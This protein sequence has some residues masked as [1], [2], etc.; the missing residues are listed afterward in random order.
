MTNS[1][2]SGFETCIQ[3]QS[4][5]VQ[6]TELA[7]QIWQVAQQSLSDEERGLVGGEIDEILNSKRAGAEE[8]L[9]RMSNLSDRASDTL[10]D[11]A[12]AHLIEDFTATCTVPVPVS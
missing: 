9:E 4:K 3:S 5:N 12:F 10:R 1:V 8:Q 6:V 11:A 7:Q 2:G